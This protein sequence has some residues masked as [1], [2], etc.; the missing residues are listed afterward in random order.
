M[1]RKVLPTHVLM[2]NIGADKNICYQLTRLTQVRRRAI[3]YLKYRYGT[4]KFMTL[5]EKN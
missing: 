3:V 5:T 2:Y 4:T 1:L